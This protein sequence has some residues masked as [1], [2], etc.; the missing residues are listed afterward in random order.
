MII[1]VAL[2]DF[3]IKNIQ[4]FLP[5]T[6]IIPGQV[7]PIEILSYW[8][9]SI[10]KNIIIGA[11]ILVSTL[12]LF[13]LMSKTPKISIV[14]Y[15]FEMLIPLIAFFIGIYLWTLP[16]GNLDY[17]R[18]YRTANIVNELGLIEYFGKWKPSGTDLPFIPIVYGLL[19]NIF[20]VSRVVIQIFNTICFAFTSYLIFKIGSMIWNRNVGLCAS[21]IPLITLPY[22]LQVPSTLVDIPYVF[23]IV[24]FTYLLLVTYRSRFWQ[25]SAVLTILL[26]PLIL[27]SKATSS[28][29]I[30][31]IFTAL[32]VIEVYRT[33]ERKPVFLKALFILIG[34]SV[35]SCS[36]VS[37]Y[38]S[39]LLLFY[40]GLRSRPELETGIAFPALHA[41]FNLVFK[42]W[43]IRNPIFSIRNIVYLFGSVVTILSFFSIVYLIKKQDLRSVLLFGWIFIPIFF[44]PG[45]HR[46]DLVRYFFPSI[47]AFA[48]GS[49]YILSNF[50]PK[51]RHLLLASI[52]LSSLLTA[53][54]IE[55]PIR[56]ATGM[57]AIKYSCDFVN[58]LEVDS[59]G[60]V[61]VAETEWGKKL[62]TKGVQGQLI[63]HFNYQ[64]HNKLRYY[65]VNEILSESDELPQI[66][67]V[68]SDT[69]NIPGSLESLTI[70][71]YD[72]ISIREGYLGGA[73]SPLICSIYSL[74]EKSI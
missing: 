25:V 10:N 51:I 43:I 31:V 60:L 49:A 4:R 50:K 9:S 61:H 62:T 52:V 11:I 1:F 56:N 37:L 27:L 67:I 29:Y 73:W 64:L 54:L 38:H 15:R 7:V 39:K 65:E 59:V 21:I 66:L 41:I 16:E 28:I 47:P 58:S 17:Y 63:I 33:K 12:V 3:L 44:V 14:D 22:V 74:K 35:L 48:L 13:I 71:R 2:S 34:A 36:L 72:L 40:G 53:S 6:R 55:I 5:P 42:A 26:I 19:F 45:G 68:V 69:H 30:P 32:T 18:Y 24:L 70:F 57:A 20:G 46:F 23:L 8:F